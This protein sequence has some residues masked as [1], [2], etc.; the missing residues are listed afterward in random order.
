MRGLE[1]PLQCTIRAGAGLQHPHTLTAAD[2]SQLSSLPAMTEQVT[3]WLAGLLEELT[4]L[5]TAMR[6]LDGE[7]SRIDMMVD[8]GLCWISWEEAEGA[9]A[10]VQRYC[11]IVFLTGD[12]LML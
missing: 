8:A 11:K 2:S 6:V 9:V 12:A 7:V 10:L 5:A 1:P 3:R 4:P